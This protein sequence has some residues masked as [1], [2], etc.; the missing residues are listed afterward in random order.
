MYG[1]RPVS[2]RPRMATAWPFSKSVP[3]AAAVRPVALPQH[4]HHVEPEPPQVQ[5]L[6]SHNSHAAL[7]PGKVSS[8]L[9]E[10]R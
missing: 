8:E 4:K 7:L 9:A 1:H 2:R 5:A 6:V 10:D 3:T